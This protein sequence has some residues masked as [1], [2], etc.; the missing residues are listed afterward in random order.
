MRIL[1]DQ[2][3]PVP[4]S[5]HLTGHIVGISADLGWARLRNGELLAAAEEAGYELLLTTDK[6]LRYQQNLT[7]RKIAIV[8]IGHSQWPTLEPHV[9][10]VV[11]A[12]E[13]ALPGSYTEVEIPL[14]LRKFGKHEV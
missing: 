7:D 5:R 14:P 9:V 2:G 8:V 10:R 13:A 6:N 4:M 12:V 1:F 3:T 11:K